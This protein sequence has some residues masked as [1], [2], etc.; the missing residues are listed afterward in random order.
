MR[1][2]WPVSCA[3]MNFYIKIESSEAV[4]YLLR[5]KGHMWIDIW[6]GSEREGHP[7]GSLS[8]SYGAFLPGLFSWSSCFAWF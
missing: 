7:C 6:A 4:K 5:G 3:E 8:H 1:R 2:P